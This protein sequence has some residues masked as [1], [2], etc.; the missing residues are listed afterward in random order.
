VGISIIASHLSHIPLGLFIFSL[1]LPFLFFGYKEIGKTE[2]KAAFIVC[3]FPE[4]MAELKRGVFINFI[5][6]DFCIKN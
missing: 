6:S 1:N 5:Y 2:E 3:D 4:K